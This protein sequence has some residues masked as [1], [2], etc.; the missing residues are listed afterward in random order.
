MQ[1]LAVPS[2]AAAWIDQIPNWNGIKKKQHQ[3]L[4]IYNFLRADRDK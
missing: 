1:S 3:P 2:P 4:L